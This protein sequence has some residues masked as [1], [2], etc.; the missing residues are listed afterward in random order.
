MNDR[1]IPTEAPNRQTS[2]PSAFWLLFAFVPTVVIIACFRANSDWMSP[3]L[4]LTAACSIVST[5]GLVRS[6]KNIIVRF[7]LGLFL[8]VFFFFANWLVAVFVGCSIR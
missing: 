6:V 5:I 3:L 1:T 7:L 4:V 2:L 8:C